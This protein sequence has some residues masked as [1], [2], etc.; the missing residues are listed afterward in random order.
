MIGN[1]LCRVD[2]LFLK[3]CDMHLSSKQD[4]TGSDSFVWPGLPPQESDNN[5]FYYDLTVC[6]FVVIS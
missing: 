6:Y 4:S 1:G 3:S 5:D 2:K